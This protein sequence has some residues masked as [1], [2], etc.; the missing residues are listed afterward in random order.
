VCA[1]LLVREEG[2]SYAAA[3]LRLGITRAGVCQLIVRGQRQLR[4]A[5]ADEGF[6]VRTEGGGEGR[7][8]GD[9]GE[10]IDAGRKA[11]SKEWQ[12]RTVQ[13]M[14]HDASMY[15]RREIERREMAEEG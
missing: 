15:F 5:L 11:A 2:L 3:A 13:G 8:T 14:L 6:D 10:L 7:D 9:D 1:L 4:Q 12:V